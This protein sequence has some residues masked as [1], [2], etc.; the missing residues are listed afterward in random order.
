ME[1]DRLGIRF[2]WDAAKAE[3]NRT[4]HR[5]SFQEA[6]EVFFDPFL[7]LEPN[8][9][10]A[11]EQRQIAIGLT[12]SWAMLF[13]VHVELDDSI[14]VISARRASPSQRKRYEAQ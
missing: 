1:F 7:V 4:R 2:I 10:D 3:V 9:K 6:S 11:R 5:I 12:S 8:L 13:V 14:R